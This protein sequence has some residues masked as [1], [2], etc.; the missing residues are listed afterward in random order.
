MLR[1]LT[2]CC[3]FFLTETATTEISSLSLHDAL[4]I[5]PARGHAAVR[6]PLLDGQ[7]AD[8]PQR[9]PRRVSG[10]DV[11]GA[12]R[13]PTG[14]LSARARAP[15]HSRTPPPEAPEIGRASCRER[16]WIEGEG[17]A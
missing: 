1:T 10:T 14:A 3:L 5:C 8:P 15:G 11:P 13:A 4:P 17:G 9:C 2:T 16:G 7:R 6:D 12:S